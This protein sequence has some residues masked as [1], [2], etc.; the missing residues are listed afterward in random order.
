MYTLG[1]FFANSSGHPGYGRMR[2]THRIFFKNLSSQIN[3]KLPFFERLEFLQIDILRDLL[4]HLR[5]DFF[6]LL[7]A[8]NS[9]L[10]IL[11]RKKF[12]HNTGHLV[13]TNWDN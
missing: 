5:T 12:V 8:Q 6:S 3:R 9:Y 4:I 1:D 10:E 11:L 7:E 13:L 2:R